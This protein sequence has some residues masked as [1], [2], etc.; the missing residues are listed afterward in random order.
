M[1]GED[2]LMKS[3]IDKYPLVVMY[4]LPI[5][6]VDAVADTAAVNAIIKGGFKGCVKLFERPVMVVK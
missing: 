3:I 5:N 1:P 2:T 4:Q 6:A